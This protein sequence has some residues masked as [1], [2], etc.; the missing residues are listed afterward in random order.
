MWVFFADS[1]LASAARRV[2]VFLVREAMTVRAELDLSSYDRLFPSQDFLPRQGF[3]NLIALPLQG[4][5]RRNGTT[6]F[7][8]PVTLEPYGDQWEFLSSLGRMSRKAVTSLANSIGELAVGPM[9]GTYRRPTRSDANMSVPNP[10]RAS[11]REALSDRQYRAPTRGDRGLETCR[12]VA[13]PG[14]LREGTQPFLDG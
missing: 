6:I 7:L 5:C 9:S 1:V 4:E 10:I 3:G 8:D 12:V 14:L 2:G 13:E 11:A